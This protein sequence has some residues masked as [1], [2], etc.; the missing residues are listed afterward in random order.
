VLTGYDIYYFA[1]QHVSKVAFYSRIYCFYIIEFESVS[2]KFLDGSIAAS[3]FWVNVSE[4]A[5]YF[6]G[7]VEFLA[8]PDWKLRSTFTRCVLVPW[9]TVMFFTVA[10][11]RAVFFLRAYLIQVDFICYYLFLPARSSL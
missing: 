10:V 8:D 6:F 7:T 11:K 5:T 3:Y 4:I 1:L 2:V 9:Y